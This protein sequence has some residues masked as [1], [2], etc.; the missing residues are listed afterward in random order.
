M[1]VFTIKPKRINPPVLE[2]HLERLFDTVN[3]L[4]DAHK[5][6]ETEILR[7]RRHVTRLND[8]TAALVERMDA[9]ES[10]ISAHNHP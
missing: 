7:L 1:A 8:L 9:A 5:Q 6:Q 10:E 4:V 2:S 3:A